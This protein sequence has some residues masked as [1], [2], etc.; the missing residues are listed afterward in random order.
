MRPRLLCGVPPMSAAALPSPP[1][2]SELQALLGAEG[3]RPSARFG[4]NFLVDPALLAAVPRDAGVVPGERVLEVGPGVGSLT[5]P[6]LDTGAEVL[7]VEVDRGL[8][9]LLRRR[10][11]APLVEGRLRL[12][13]GDV[14]DRDERCHP[15]VEDWWA[16]GPPPR[17]VSNL[18]YAISGPFLARLPG[19]PL[20]GATLLLQREVADKAAGPRDPAGP[21]SP[22]AV[23]LRLGFTVRLG[24]RVP[25]EVFWPRPRVD[26][27]FLHLEPRPD[28]L[29]PAADAV[30]REWLRVGFAERRKR[31][32]PR[33]ARRVPEAAAA[34]ERVGVGAEARPEQVAPEV[35]AQALRQVVEWGEVEDQE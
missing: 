27:A 34:L 13:E 11:A 15:E 1:G 26:S 18:P 29:P 17:V 6:L 9:D 5:V 31:L 24:R 28:A 32:L 33:L 20:A 14:L 8:A 2:R 16:A 10:L 21:W 12:V 3:L 7:A 25:P 30:L 35:W 22:L 23:R 19:R 4:Q